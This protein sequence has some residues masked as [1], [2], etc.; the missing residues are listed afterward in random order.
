MCGFQGPSGE[1]GKSGLDGKPVSGSGSLLVKRYEIYKRFDCFLYCDHL[2]LDCMVVF[3]DVRRDRRSSDAR[4]K[5]RW[6]Y[7]VWI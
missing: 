6:M 7:D 4:K 2:R 3:N 1:P 5:T